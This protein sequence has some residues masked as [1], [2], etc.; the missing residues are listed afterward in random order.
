MADSILHVFPKFSDPTKGTAL[1][2]CKHY[3]CALGKAGV[4]NA[5]DGREGDAKTPAGIYQVKYGFYRADRLSKPV[6]ALT[7]TSL[8]ENDGWCDQVGDPLYNQAVKHPT[9]VSAEK[10]WRDDN[11][12]NIILVTSH[13][14]GPSKR[15]LGSAIFIHVARLGYKPTMGCIAFDQNDLLDILKNVDNG[16]IIRIHEKTID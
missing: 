16:T 9:N 12:Y 8:E 6:T 2:Q 1:W 11:L 15:D 5:V 14:D 4:I 3:D 13:N 7:L 10:L